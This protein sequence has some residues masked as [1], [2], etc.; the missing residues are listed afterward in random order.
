VQAIAS[1]ALDL[2]ERLQLPSTELG[3]GKAA[4]RLLDESF[5]TNIRPRAMKIR[6]GAFLP[7]SL[8]AV[9]SLASAQVAELPQRVAAGDV[10]TTQAILWARSAVAGTL[11][12][13]IDDD[14]TF[15]TPLV[16]SAVVSDTTLPAK[17]LVR[18]LTPGTT[19]YYEVTSPTG[20]QDTG[21]FRTARTSTSIDGLRF[22]VSGD[23][24]GDVMP[25][26]SIANAP[27]RDLD[28][29][30]IL[31]DTIYADVQSPALPGVTQALTLLEFRAKHAEVNSAFAGV[32]GL[33]DLR[34]STAIWA[35]IDDHE[36]TNDF[37]GGAAPSSDLTFDQTGNFIN[38]TNLYRNG[39]RAFTEYF[40]LLRNAYGA[41]GEARTAFKRKLYRKQRYGG[42]ATVLM[43]DARSFRDQGLPAADPTN[44]SSV[45]NFLV[46]SFNP[47]RTMLGRAQIDELKADLLEADQQGVTWKFVFV[48]EPMQNLGVVAA[49]DRF[50][51]YAAE[52]TEILA[53]IAAN[54]IDNVVFVAADIHGTIVNDVT[55][56]LAPG[57]AQIPTG[58]FEITTGAIAYDAPFGPTVVGLAAQLGL[59]T[60]TDY[61][62][63]LG[64][65]TAFKDVFVQQLVDGQLAQLGYTPVGL[66]GS[67]VN[68]TLVSG[69]YVATHVYGWSE[70]EIA[71]TTG[72][73]TV[74]T[75]GVDPATPTATPVV[76]SQF[77][78]TPQ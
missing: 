52:R 15:A 41:T 55:Y 58:A 19:Y 60:P 18:G 56:Q 71:P 5:H 2:D 72:V 78:V 38:E 47:T 70:F 33:G 65:P 49:S 20:T 35:T 8:L 42:D 16:R 63:Y 1:S 53:H 40:P 59:I 69:G 28:F 29:F 76:S 45:L 74:T 73:L 39:L 37:S 64:L 48:P 22:G 44:P 77:T 62:T 57:G 13:R 17:G 14:P 54:D 67:A 30:A 9:G 4:W 31:G 11:T 43:L 34:R 24:R 75:Y 51:G 21:T 23:S 46:Q 61:Q 7:S 66:Q 36:V 68:A 50:E 3:R 26:G 25:F 12:F 32:N 10:T 27:A 6:T